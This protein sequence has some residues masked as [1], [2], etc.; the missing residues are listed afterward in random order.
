MERVFN[1]MNIK[2]TVGFAIAIRDYMC[3]VAFDYPDRVTL[4]AA[5][6]NAAQLDTSTQTDAGL[7]IKY[8]DWLPV[9]IITP[10]GEWF[11]WDADNSIGAITLHTF[12]DILM[13]R[14]DRVTSQML[15]A[16]STVKVGEL[17]AVLVYNSVRFPEPSLKASHQRIDASKALE[18]WAQ[19]TGALA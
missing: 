3:Q 6:T 18:T 4:I 19:Y 8:C 16:G 5:D 7:I 2:N 9:S 15:A 10:V 14:V 17:Y 1:I 11:A 13:N 12:D